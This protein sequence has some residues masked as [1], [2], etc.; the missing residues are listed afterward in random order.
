MKR[1][2]AIVLAALLLLAAAY[3]VASNALAQKEYKAQRFDVEVDVRPDGTLLVTETVVFEFTG[4][5]FTQVFRELPDEKVDRVEVVSAALDGTTLDRGDDAG[6]VGISGGTP[7][8]VVWHPPPTSDETHTFTLIYRV[9]GAVEQ[10]SGVDRLVWQALPE[11]REYPI[12]ASRVTVIY[13]DG[14]RLAGEPAVEYGNA[15]LETTPGRVVFQARD[16]DVED[17]LIIRIP[18]EPGS[19]V[20]VPPEW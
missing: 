2:Y 15:R 18:F 7:I 19:L 20:T 8:E 13:P 10:I 5:P 6:Q 12:D 9:E 14:V 11:E 17:L 4:G 16:V 1:F 3:P